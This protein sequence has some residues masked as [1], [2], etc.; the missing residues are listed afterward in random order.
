[1]EALRELGFSA[2]GQVVQYV[3]DSRVAGKKVGWISG[4]L[5]RKGFESKK[6]CG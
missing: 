2:E 6:E 1:M 5:L 3:Q 4:G